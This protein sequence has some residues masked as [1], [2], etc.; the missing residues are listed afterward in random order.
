V[1]DIILLEEGAHFQLLA[2][3]ALG[4]SRPFG[5][6]VLEQQWKIGKLVPADAHVAD[7]G[8]IVLPKG[9]GKPAK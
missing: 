2:A 6:G 3:A 1:N 8:Q 9:A 7:G 4:G 5:P